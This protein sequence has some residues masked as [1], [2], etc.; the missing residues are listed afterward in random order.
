G[1]AWATVAGAA[2]VSERV[3]RGHRVPVQGLSDALMG[4]AGAIG[5]AGSGLVLAFWGFS[6]LNVACL[7]L[8]VLVGL[9]GVAELRRHRRTILEVG[10][11]DA[12][13]G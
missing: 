12:V 1:W 3:E 7:V 6:G 10:Y 5:A 9:G 2:C 11:D 13:A 8:V 4:A